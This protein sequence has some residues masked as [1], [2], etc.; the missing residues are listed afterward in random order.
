[1]FESTGSG[2]LLVTENKSNLADLFEPG[3]EV[4]AYDSPRQAA[5]L[6]RDVLND[7]Q[8]LDRIAQAGQQRTLTSHTYT[9]RAKQVTQ[10][11]ETYLAAK[12]N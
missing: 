4:L 10:I 8:R 12:K 1:M 7:P 5:E 2:A 6:A 3:K 11:F 9:A